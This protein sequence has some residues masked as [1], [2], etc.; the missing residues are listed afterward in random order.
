MPIVWYIPNYKQL[1]LPTMGHPGHQ[2][3]DGMPFIGKQEAAQPWGFRG[4]TQ[5]GLNYGIETSNGGHRSMSFTGTPI[6]RRWAGAIVLTLALN[7]HAIW[8][9]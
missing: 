5:D 8:G 7:R 9:M 3:N 1:G 2:L 6:I 4:S